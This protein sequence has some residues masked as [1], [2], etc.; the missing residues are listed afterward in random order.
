MKK[1]SKSPNVTSFY[2]DV[3]NA[4]VSDLRKI[5]GIPFSE[6]NDGQDK[7]NFEWVMENEKGEVFTVYD[8][9]EYRV[10]NEDELI[11][12]HIGGHSSLSTGLA[13]NEIAR[14]LNEL[15]A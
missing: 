1:T 4:S 5:L 7:V 14:A 6:T 9:K 10:L 11:V 8:W 13:V 12:W 3:F 15:E 2:N